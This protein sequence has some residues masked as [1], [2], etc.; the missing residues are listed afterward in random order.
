MKKKSITSRESFGEI[1]II[2]KRKEIDESLNRHSKKVDFPGEFKHNGETINL[3][4]DIANSFNTFFSQSEKNCPI[5]L[6]L[7]TSFMEHT[8]YIFG[9]QQ[10]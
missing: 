6:M 7:T 8:K 5:A 9:P 3:P 2:K 1:K 4:L 10:I